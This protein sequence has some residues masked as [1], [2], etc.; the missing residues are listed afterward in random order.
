MKAFRRFASGAQAHKCNYTVHILELH[1]IH[2]SLR[3]ANLCIFWRRR[4]ESGTT[5]SHQVQPSPDG[6]YRYVFFG[7]QVKFAATMFQRDEGFEEKLLDLKIK[8]VQRGGSSTV[9]KVSFNIAQ[10]KP[11]QGEPYDA[12]VTFESK[13]MVWGKLKM[14]I[15][16]DLRQSGNASDMSASDLSMASDAS[17]TSNA[18]EFEDGLDPIPTDRA[19]P[20]FGRASASNSTLQ[21]EP[22]QLM[23][24]LSQMTA[25]QLRDRIGQDNVK[26]GR[27]LQLREDAVRALEERVEELL[28]DLD[29]KEQECQA[30]TTQAENTRLAMSA[31]IRQTELQLSQHVGE[32]AA[33]VEGYQLV[34]DEGGPTYAIFTVLVSMGQ[35][36]YRLEHRFSEFAVLHEKISQRYTLPPDQSLPPFPSTTWLKDNSKQFLDKRTKA[37]NTWLTGVMEFDAIKSDKDMTHF[38]ELNGVLQL[39][40]SMKNNVVQVAA[41][42]DIG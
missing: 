16:N 24:E 8:R 30:L 40:A 29:A 28:S 13:K 18:S 22:K 20:V 34:Q 21:V 31:H 3:D 23:S 26:H 37:L 36:S 42:A 33:A 41:N 10:C 11:G 19:R 27:R 1:S 38:L 2:D 32:C 12:V 9:A 39:L 15:T 4:A 17:E 35:C 7:H 25:A 6:S 14:R 5:P